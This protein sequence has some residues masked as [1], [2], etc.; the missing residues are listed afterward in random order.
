[1]YPTLQRFAEFLRARKK[2]F[3]SSGYRYLRTL[4]GGQGSQL[5]LNSEKAFTREP[6]DDTRVIPQIHEKWESC[7]CGSHVSIAGHE[8]EVRA[9]C[10]QFRRRHQHCAHNI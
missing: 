6:L 5:S 10:Y 1:M 4:R 3:F 7:S 8:W 9:V 2:S